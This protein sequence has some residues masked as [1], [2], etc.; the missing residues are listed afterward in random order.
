MSLP[1]SDDDL[2]LVVLWR[3]QLEPKKQYTQFWLA[4]RRVLKRKRSDFGNGKSKTN[5]F[6]LPCLLRYMCHKPPSFYFLHLLL[7]LFLATPLTSQ[8][9]F[10]FAFSLLPISSSSPPCRR[11]LSSLSRQNF[12]EK[13]G[14]IDASAQQH[15]H[16]ARLQRRVRRRFGSHT[17]F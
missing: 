10:L 7:S 8:A 6:A 15:Q 17:C 14:T 16:H 9:F 3:Y 1:F 13:I 11:E 5:S 12:F 2:S 4:I